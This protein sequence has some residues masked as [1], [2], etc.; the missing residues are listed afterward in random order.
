M[1]NGGTDHDSQLLGE[2][3]IIDYLIPSA[4]VS[5][6]RKDLFESPW[7]IFL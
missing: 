2:S 3:G 1:E 5:K 6:I 7:V 4:T